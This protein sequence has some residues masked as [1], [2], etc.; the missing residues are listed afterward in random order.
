MERMC[1]MREMERE[2]ETRASSWS[3]AQC[4]FVVSREDEGELK[5]AS[6]R[7]RAAVQQ[8]RSK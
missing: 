5:G 7:R 3:V 8:Q 2:E 1:D 4:L 6:E